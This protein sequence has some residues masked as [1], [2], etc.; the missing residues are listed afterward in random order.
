MTEEDVIQ[1]NYEHF[2]GLFP[3]SC[4][5]CGRS[6][7]SLRD[8]V[9]MTSPHGPVIPYDLELREL[10]PT[11]PMGTMALANCSCGSTMALT[12][13]GQPTPLIQETLD[14][15]RMESK[16]RGI[17]GRQILAEVRNKIRQRAM[18][19]PSEKPEK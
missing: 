6:Y 9:L 18:A 2:S 19:E 8:Y 13:Q 17:S 4:H 16:K 5:A 10:Q 3:K 15:I 14:W 12:T 1:R 7:A 11:D